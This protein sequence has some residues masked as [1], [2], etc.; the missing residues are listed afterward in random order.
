MSA[1]TSGFFNLRIPHIAY[2]HAGYRRLRRY[3]YFCWQ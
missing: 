2:A 3:Q 1:A